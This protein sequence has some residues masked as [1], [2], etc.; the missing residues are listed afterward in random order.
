MENHANS[1]NF[2]IYT[3]AENSNGPD[4]TSRSRSASVLNKTSK[5]G[6]T[7]VGTVSLAATTANAVNGQYN[8][9]RSLKRP[10]GSPVV[11]NGANGKI[12]LANS[13]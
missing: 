5:T 11:T 2:P 6:K 3:N 7:K 9:A 1:I 10:N 8:R 12:R 4:N 13:G